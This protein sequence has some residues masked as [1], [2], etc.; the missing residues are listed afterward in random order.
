MGTN[1]A[2]YD[3]SETSA[4]LIFA[5]YGPDGVIELQFSPRPDFAF[6]VCPIV[7]IPRAA[8]VGFV[9]LNQRTTYFVRSRGRR[10]SGAVEDWS[11]PIALRTADGNARATAPAAVLIEPAIVV[12]PEPVLTWEGAGTVA[13]FP[14][15]NLAVDAPVSWKST[16]VADALTTI[17]F[18]TGG[19]PVDTLALLNTNFSE[20]C[21]VSIAAAGT[22]AGLAAA[23]LLVDTA[24]FRASAN[25]PGRMGYHGLWRFA[26]TKLPWFRVT[27]AGAV[28]AN[29]FSAEHL[30]IGQNRVTKNHSVDK[31]ETPL[32]RTT[33]DRTRF[34]LPDRARG[35][36]MRKV[37]F[38]ISMLTEAQY[39][40]AYG[41]LGRYENEPVLVV[42]N[43]KAGGF[44]HDRI[45]FGDL[46]GSRIFNPA[47]PRYTRTFVIESL[48]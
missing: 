28:P 10:A 36:P 14:A 5:G 22:Q 20:A 31:S 7:S 11:A 16:G 45:L 19:S 18:Q 46:K 30:V 43:S 38:E 33:I 48:I 44:F 37:E 1:V 34:G 8:Q 42:P 2:I 39:E 4:T 13:G 35:L 47:S 32:P 24:P 26:S 29:Y 12:V 6:C 17:D 41:D 23:G 9:G 27:I 3:V 25:L 21:R 40:E 15:S